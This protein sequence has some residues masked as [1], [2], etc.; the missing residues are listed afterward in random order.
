M[1]G[2]GSGEGGIGDDKEVDTFQQHDAS[3]TVS[4]IAWTVQRKKSSCHE[5]D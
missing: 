5:L 1:R 2:E 4:A 3:K